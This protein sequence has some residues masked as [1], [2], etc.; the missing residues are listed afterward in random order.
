MK[1]TL[2]K[3]IRTESRTHGYTS[4]RLTGR[5]FAARKPSVIGQLSVV[6]SQAEG[7]LKMDSSVNSE[8]ASRCLCRARSEEK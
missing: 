2:N 3:F 6:S 4:E 1:N 7:R 5:G 8:F